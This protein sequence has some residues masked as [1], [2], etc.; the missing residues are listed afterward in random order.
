MD[1][2]VRAAV[3]PEESHTPEEERAIREYQNA[4]VDKGLVE[5]A[6][7]AKSTSNDEANR[8]NYLLRETTEREV[9]DI[10]KAVGVDKRIYLSYKR[11]YFPAC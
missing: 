5:F 4:P 1:G 11:E 6:Q 9:A 10:K 8:M 7:K 3:S 2:R